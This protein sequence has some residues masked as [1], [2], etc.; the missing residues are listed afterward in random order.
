MFFIADTTDPCLTA[1]FS[2]ERGVI[3]DAQPIR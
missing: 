1:V 2:N 3:Y